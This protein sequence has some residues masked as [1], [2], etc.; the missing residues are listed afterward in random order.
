M[1]NINKFKYFYFLLQ[2][3]NI[4]RN[5]SYKNYIKLQSDKKV[6][7][8]YIGNIQKLLQYIFFIYE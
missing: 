8:K 4:Y 1:I 2:Q 7:I 6:K 3:L 5:N